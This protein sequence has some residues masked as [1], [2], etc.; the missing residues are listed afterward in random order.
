MTGLD[1]VHSLM[2]L[3]VC[4]GA[5]S[6]FVS[7]WPPAER[8]VALYAWSAHAVSACAIVA[9]YLYY[10]GGGDL[11]HYFRMGRFLASYVEYDLVAH[12]PQLVE[13]L[14]Q[15]EPDLPTAIVGDGTSTSSMVAVGGLIC[16]ATTSIWAGSILVSSLAAFGQALLWLGLRD[17]IAQSFR[18][19]ALLSCMLVPSVVFWSSSLLKEAFALVGIGVLV[20]GASRV[21]AGAFR[22]GLSSVLLGAFVVGLF[23]PYILFPLA[24]AAGVYFYWDR[25]ASTGGVRIRPLTFVSGGLATA[26]LVLALGALFPRYAIDS[27]TASIEN[28]Q[29]ASLTSE[30]GSD[31]RVAAPEQG[32]QGLTGLVAQAPVTIF[33]ALL[34]PVIFESRSVMMLIN[35][36]ETTVILYFLVMAFVRTGRLELMRWVWRSP[37][38]IACVTFVLLFSL[39]VGLATTNL[40]TLSRYRLP[41]MPF[42]FYVVFAANALPHIARQK[43]N[44]ARGARDAARLQA[45]DSLRGVS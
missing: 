44:A 39:A 1:I 23:K 14:L 18:K 38:I 5:F 28:Q 15:G 40:G 31:Y 41:M 24:V 22:L 32:P 37:D 4:G 34:R 6:S 10:Y 42:Y 25:A 26:A 9:V 43:R 19:Q 12:F 45:T 36:F 3:L 27:V 30:G 20:F 13:L 35:S 7:G 11:V 8:R 21:R 16:L 33:T 17:L 2:A 29:A